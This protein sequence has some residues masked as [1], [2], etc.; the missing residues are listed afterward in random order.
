[1]IQFFTFA[2]N[3]NTHETTGFAPFYLMSGRIPSLPVD[4]MFQ[5]ILRDESVGDYDS[6]LMSLVD[7]LRS[8]MLQVQHSSTSEKKHQLGQYKKRAKGLPLALGDQLLVANRGAWGNESLLTDGSWLVTQWGPQRLPCTF[9]ASEIRLVMSVW[10][11][12]TF[13]LR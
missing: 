13:S 3:R 5:A 6:N 2:C 9:I 11:T 10:C 8:A 1:M 12:V 7:D 4:L